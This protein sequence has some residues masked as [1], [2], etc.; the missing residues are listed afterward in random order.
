M[1]CA[2]LLVSALAFASAVGQAPAP[3]TPQPEGVTTLRVTSRV[4]AISAVAKSK[5]G[6]ALTSLTKDDFTLKQDGK[7]QAI[8]YF[9]KAEDLPLTF[10]V[11][12]DVSGSQRTF[13]GDESL[14]SD[15]FFRTV[16]GRPQDRAL[17]MEFDASMTQLMG[18]TNDPTRLHLAL[19]SLGLRP[20]RQGGTV[21]FDAVDAVA[22]QVLNKSTGRKAMVILTDGGDV[23]SHVKIEQ[24]IE[25][26]QRGNVQIYAVYYS[27]SR[28]S[29]PV[30]PQP[31]SGIRLDNGL[32]LL[33]RLSAATGG[34]VFMVGPGLGLQNI[35]AQIATDLRT[36]YEIGYVPPADTAPNKFH[37]LELHVKEKG[38]TV[39]ARNGFFAEP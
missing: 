32:E 19:T 7:E 8:R 18:L 3:Q 14:A 15:I 38:A 2:A 26:A 20:E 6:T 31:G 39:Q 11:M 34:R 21:L 16:L 29:G 36:Q 33:K 1:R 4:V 30:M 5:D 9:S 22:R 12:V 37:K 27:A 35:Y 25:S 24:A 23:G 13:I 28:F 17:L 10:A